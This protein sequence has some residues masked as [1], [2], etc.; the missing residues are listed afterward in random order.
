[1]VSGLVTRLPCRCAGRSRCGTPISMLAL[2]NAVQELPVVKKLRGGQGRRRAKMRSVES[3]L[4]Y[5]PR[6]HHVRSTAERHDLREGTQNAPKRS[7]PII[8]SLATLTTEN[9]VGVDARRSELSRAGPMPSATWRPTRIDSPRATDSVGRTPQNEEPCVRRQPAVA[10]GYGTSVSSRQPPA[11][12]MKR[13]RSWSRSGD[14]RQASIR[15]GT[16]YTP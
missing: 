14:P 8:S 6:R 2:W 12:W 5:P 11:S 10:G 3:F 15:S 1:M 9:G 13:R 16:R 4:T 7:P